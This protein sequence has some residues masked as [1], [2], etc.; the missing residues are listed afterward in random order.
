MNARLRL[1]VEE[2]ANSAVGLMRPLLPERQARL[3]LLSRRII[4]DQ[5]F[6]RGPPRV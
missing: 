2:V 6:L 3:R 5:P 4:A 1:L